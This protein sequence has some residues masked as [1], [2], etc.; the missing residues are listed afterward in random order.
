MSKKEDAN[1]NIISNLQAKATFTLPCCLKHD[2]NLK[3]QLY[4]VHP[5][6]DQP[7]LA[8]QTSV[9]EMKDCWFIVGESMEE[10]LESVVSA[11]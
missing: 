4:L 7:G 3:Y 10:R 11:S 6:S 9:R 5:A 1:K 8:I 2:V